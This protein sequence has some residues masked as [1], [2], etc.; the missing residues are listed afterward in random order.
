LDFRDLLCHIFAPL[1][2]L[3]CH[4][5]VGKFQ[6]QEEGLKGWNLKENTYNNNLVAAKS[7]YCYYQSPI[8]PHVAL[9]S[10]PTVIIENT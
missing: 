1:Q 9:R 10:P 5:K 7:K 2:G 8:F 4:H 6:A 3:Q